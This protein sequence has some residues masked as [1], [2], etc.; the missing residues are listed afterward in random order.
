MIWED[1]SLGGTGKLV[2]PW[3]S[4]SQARSN[5]P[6]KQ[7][8]SQSWLFG[9]ASAA[10]R[11]LAHSPAAKPSALPLPPSAR[12][13]WPNLKKLGQANNLAVPPEALKLLRISSGQ[14]GQQIV[15]ANCSETGRR[16]ADAVGDDQGLVVD[17]AAAGVDDVR[18]VAL[19][20]VRQR[21]QSG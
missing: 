18:D 15:E 11:W 8:A 3:G 2:C 14:P 19:A 4:N 10:C 21:A 12:P 16:I 9:V 13:A 7:Y 20:F 1:T 17:Q 5:E 6:V